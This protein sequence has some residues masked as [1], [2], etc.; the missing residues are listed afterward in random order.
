[1]AQRSER[2]GTAV[3]EMIEAARALPIDERMRL[4]RAV[5]DT[6]DDPVSRAIAC[7]RPGPALSA[8]EE[9]LLAELDPSTAWVSHADVQRD[10]LQRI[11]SELDRDE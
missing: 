7:A 5:A 10:L 11:A 2:R 3:D 9:A 8:R 1:M 4:V 6:I